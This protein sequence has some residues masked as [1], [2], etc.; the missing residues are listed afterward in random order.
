MLSIVLDVS[1]FQGE[2]AFGLEIQRFVA[3]VKSSAKATPGGE[4][5]MPGRS[6]NGPRRKGCGTGSTL[7]PRPGRRSW[8]RPGV[9]A[10]TKV[11]GQPSDSFTVGT[12]RAM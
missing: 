3:W 11:T 4:I 5:L 8:T 9:S 12:R 1:R 2:D 7:T 10:W 6:R